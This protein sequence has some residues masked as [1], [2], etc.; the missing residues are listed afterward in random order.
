MNDKKVL[1][2]SCRFY[3][4][5]VTLKIDGRE[6]ISDLCD[7]NFMPL[8]EGSF[9]YKCN[10]YQ[11]KS[12]VL[13]ATSELTKDMLNLVYGKANVKKSWFLNYAVT[14]IKIIDNKILEKLSSF[15][16]IEDIANF[17]FKFLAKVNEVCDE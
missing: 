12:A 11:E 9:R 15:D 13:F 6:I 10:G 17:L 1:C 2:K 14:A 4:E 16:D 3:K 5:N 8:D 7:V